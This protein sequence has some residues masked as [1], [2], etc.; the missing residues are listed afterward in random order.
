MA[1][2]VVGSRHR[3]NFQL[4]EL[5]WHVASQLGDQ[6]LG[7]AAIEKQ[8]QGRGVR[9]SLGHGY[10]GSSG[11]QIKGTGLPPPCNA[12]RIESSKVLCSPPRLRRVGGTWGFTQLHGMQLSQSSRA[13]IGNLVRFLQVPGLTRQ[14]SYV[15]M[16]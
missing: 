16:Y 2:L 12:S 14:T 5:M 15:K 3:S 13:L 1:L 10:F 8:R 11:S 9:I 4:N 6:L 7:A